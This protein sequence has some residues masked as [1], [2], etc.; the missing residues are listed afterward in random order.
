MYHCCGC[1]LATA[2]AGCGNHT[3]ISIPQ[4]GWQAG[5]QILCAG[6]LAGQAIAHPDGHAGCFFI[7]AYHLKVVVERGHLIHLGHGNIHLFGQRHQ[8]AVMQAAVSVI[9]LVQVLNQQIAPVPF[10]WFDT[11]QRTHFTNRN[12]V[13]LASL[14]FAFALDA[15]TQLVH[16]SNG[17]CFDFIDFAGMCR[18][19]HSRWQRRC[20]VGTPPEG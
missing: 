6:Q 16:S 11:D 18:M 20:V 15:L 19:V 12:V 9:E 8:M 7:T 13:R 4:Q 1:L 3:R 14:E 10:D 2:N 17:Y 5:Q